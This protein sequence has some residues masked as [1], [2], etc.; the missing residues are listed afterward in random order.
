QGRSGNAHVPTHGDL[1]HPKMMDDRPPDRMGCLLVQ[2]V[3]V[4][5]A[6]I[7]GAENGRIDH[8]LHPSIDH[9]YGGSR[10]AAFLFMI[11]RAG[12]VC[13][14]PAYPP[15]ESGISGR[16]PPGLPTYG[17]TSKSWRPVSQAWRA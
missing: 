15:G 11:G 9:A 3:R 1:R 2:G 4:D 5:A 10:E 17:Y 16:D 13:P 7:V 14:R 8:W 6:H 12:L